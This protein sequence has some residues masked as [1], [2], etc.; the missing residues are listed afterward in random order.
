M[1]GP[2][3]DEYVLTDRGRDFR[4]VMLSLM[5]WGN[6][7]F[8]PEGPSVELIH[9]ATG[10][11]GGPGPGRPASLGCQSK[12]R[13]SGYAATG[14]RRQPVPETARAAAGR[15]VGPATRGGPRHSAGSTHCARWPRGN[16][17]G[18]PS[19]SLVDWARGGGRGPVGY[20]SRSRRRSTITIRSGTIHGGIIAAVLDTVLAC[21][22]YSTLP[23]G[24]NC[25]TLEIK[26][27]YLRPITAA[28]G[29]VI[30][31]G[32]AIHTGRQV[33]VAEARILGATGPC[34]CDR[35]HDPC[36]CST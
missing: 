34:L 36:W 35:Q 6:R 1:S 18:H 8:A 4:P 25:V 23:A 28:V 11:P 15:P 16:G 12:A 24:R 5:N 33:G 3:R 17:R 20:G 27:N 9:A 31:E 13:N 2:P 10:R 22:V 21:S 29:E 19:A 26:V 14:R 30:G 7:H 32:V